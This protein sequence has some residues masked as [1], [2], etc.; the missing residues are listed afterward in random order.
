[1]VPS[2]RQIEIEIEAV[3]ADQVTLGTPK[4]RGAMIAV[5]WEINQA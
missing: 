3:S 2:G 4:R 1:M 5:S